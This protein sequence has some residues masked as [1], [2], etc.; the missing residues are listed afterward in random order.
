MSLCYNQ[1]MK[2]K[3][4]FFT[5]CI[6]SGD[7]QRLA[8]WYEDIFEFEVSDT[9]DLSDDTGIGFSLNKENYI[10]IGKHDQ[11]T[12]QS[13]DPFRIMV[14]FQ[15][16]SVK[17]AAAELNDK[18]VE[19]VADPF[20]APPGGFWCATFKDIDGNLLQIEGDE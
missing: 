6:W 17:Q 12:G 2:L 3:N 9:L 19:F 16:E 18:G 15:V 4:T 10:W 14:G 5:I 1:V 13:K 20:L 11:I 7:Y 8:K